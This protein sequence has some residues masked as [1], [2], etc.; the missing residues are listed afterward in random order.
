M[1]GRHFIL[2]KKLM[3]FR[4]SRVR[5]RHVEF[6]VTRDFRSSKFFVPAGRE[7]SANVESLLVL[8][9]ERRRSLRYGGRGMIWRHAKQVCPLC[10]LGPTPAGPNNTLFAGNDSSDLLKSTSV[11]LLLFENIFKMYEDVIRCFAKH[12]K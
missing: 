9:A 3:P 11:G 2:L 8:A 6:K 10:C 5:S 1:T 7:S 12:C 4:N